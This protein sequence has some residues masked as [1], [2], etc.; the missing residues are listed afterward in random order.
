MVWIVLILCI[1]RYAGHLTLPESLFITDPR[2]EYRATV[3]SLSFLIQHPSSPPSRPSSATTNILFDL[4]IKRDL[5]GYA[6]AQEA[7]IAHRQPV[8]TDPDCAASLRRGADASG[9]DDKPLLDPKRE[10]DLV[11]LSHVHWD[12]VGTPGDFESASF[13]VGSGTLDLLR[14]GAGHLYPAA[15]FNDEEIPPSRTAELPPVTPRV[16]AP[17]QYAEPKHTPPPAS[18][19]ANNLPP[20]FRGLEWKPLASFPNALDLF[21]D[22]SLYVIDSPGHL[23]GHVNALARVGP[24]KYVYLGGDCCH[25]PRILRGDKGIAEY[26]DGR[27]GRRSVHV[28]TGVAKGTLDRIAEFV[29]SRRIEGEEV[30]VE[31][32]VAHD[33]E[34]RGKNRGR[35]WPGHL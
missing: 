1:D 19:L 5:S 23:Y 26:D 16:D 12:H 18:L 34:W 11:V 17:A 13:V 27:G 4:G 9:S 28:H 35:F 29:R 31:V 8:I 32:V 14:N 3:P 7:H 22:G 20:S 25:D 30:Q 10:V 21:G 15:I 6:P 33:G 2:P 24:G